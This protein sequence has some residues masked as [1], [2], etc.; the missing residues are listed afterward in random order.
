MET[1]SGRVLKIEIR[2][3]MVKDTDPAAVRCDEPP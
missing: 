1:R 3:F 2:D